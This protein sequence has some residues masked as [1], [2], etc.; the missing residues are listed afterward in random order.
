MNSE[1]ALP[2]DIHDYYEQGGEIG[3]LDR[4]IGLL[5]LAR[6]QELIKR[7]LP[8][9]SATVLDVGGGPGRYAAWLARAGYTVHLLDAVPLHVEQATAVSDSQPEAPIASIRLG[10]A[11]AL[12]YD[13]GRAAA[14]LLHGPLYHLTE[15]ADR[16]RALHEARRVLQAGGLLLA[17]AVSRYASALVG[18]HR[19]W[20][21]NAD[22][23]AMLDVELANGQHRPPPSWP[24]FFTTA[25]FHHPEELQAELQAAGFKV[26]ALLAVQGPGWIVPDIEAL[27]RDETARALLLE[28]VRKLEAEPA[29]LGMSP[30]VLAVGEKTA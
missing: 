3:R 24:G 2:Q 11:R 26:R 18:L 10:D 28:T 13:T 9:P 27:M 25:H 1:P 12:P 7:F 15:P 29:L 19:W 30:H 6:T 20:L 5:E 22:F 14:L 21:D 4:G 17:V 8:P 16:L 23:R